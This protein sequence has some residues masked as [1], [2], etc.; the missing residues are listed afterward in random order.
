MRI[1]AGS[2]IRPYQD[3]IHCLIWL[4]ITAEGGRIELVYEVHD[5]HKSSIGKFSGKA[6]MNCVR[7]GMWLEPEDVPN[8]TEV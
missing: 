7:C 6:R 1:L 3:G 5:S 8:G 2:L 4:G